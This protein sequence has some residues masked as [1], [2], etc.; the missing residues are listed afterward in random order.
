MKTL[1]RP[2]ISIWTFLLLKVVI[3]YKL[4][5]TLSLLKS[6]DFTNQNKIL[7]IY[8]AQSLTFTTCETNIV[9]KMPWK[10]FS[11]LESSR[12]VLLIMINMVRVTQCTLEESLEISY[13][14]VNIVKGTI[15][16]SLSELGHFIKKC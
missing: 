10:I 15:T 9:L 14:S 8:I 1:E 4:T 5:R 12:K 3:F 6:S 16:T 2:G 7:S 13:R 11:F